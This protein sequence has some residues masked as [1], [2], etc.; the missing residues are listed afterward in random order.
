M[1]SL[2][3]DPMKEYF[4][5]SSLEEAFKLKQINYGLDLS[6]KKW[7]LLKEPEGDVYITFFK[8]DEVFVYCCAFI[9]F[10]DHVRINFSLNMSSRKIM[11]MTGS[12]FNGYVDEKIKSLKDLKLHFNFDKMPVSNF[13]SVFNEVFYVMNEGIKKF[14][15]KEIRFRGYAE[16]LHKIYLRMTTDVNFL[17]ELKKLGYG[18]KEITKGGFVCFNKLKGNWKDLI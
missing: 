8:H 10:Q 3:E 17:N 12:E 9:F 13:L 4:Y 18:F 15:P 2:D 6:D 16:K 11:N 5:L 14:K 1:W 7:K